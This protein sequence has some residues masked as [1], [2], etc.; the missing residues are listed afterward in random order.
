MIIF[1]NVD[2]MSVIKYLLF[3]DLFYDKKNSVVEKVFRK[4]KNRNVF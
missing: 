1:F 4:V 2:E 3:Y